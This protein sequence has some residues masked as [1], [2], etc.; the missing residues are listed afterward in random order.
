MIMREVVKCSDSD[1][2]ITCGGLVLA[3]HTTRHARMRLTGDTG[4]VEISGKCSRRVVDQP[5]HLQFYAMRYQ[6]HYSD[7][8]LVLVVVQFR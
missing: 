2:P 3:T 4:I 1:S 5:Q 6:Q 8:T 7:Y